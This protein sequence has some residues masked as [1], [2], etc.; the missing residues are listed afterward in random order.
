MQSDVKQFG[1]IPE[2]IGRIPVLTALKPLDAE[3]LKSILMKT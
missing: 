1:L 3:T 2:I